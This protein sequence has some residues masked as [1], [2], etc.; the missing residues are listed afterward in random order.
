MGDTYV[1]AVKNWQ[2][3]K[4]SKAVEKFFGFA[5]YHRIF[6]RRFSQSPL[7]SADRKGE[8]YLETEQQ[9]AFDTLIEALTIPPM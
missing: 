1:E 8:Y 5:N 7:I 9:E 6:I 4:N 3:P 2:A